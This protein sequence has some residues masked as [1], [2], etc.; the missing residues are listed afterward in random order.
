VGSEFMEGGFYENVC[1][2]SSLEKDMQHKNFIVFELTQIKKD[3]FLVS[4]V[5]SILFDTIESKILSDRSTRGMLIF[6]EYAETQSM[7]D[8]FSGDDIHSTV[9]FCYQ[10][11]RKENGAVMTII[12][13]PAQLPDNNYTKG[14]IGNTQVLYVLPT[15]ETVYDQIIEAFHIKNNSHINLMKSIK[16][17]FNGKNPHSELFIRFQDLYATAV[18]LELSPEKYYAFQTEGEEWTAIQ[19]MYAQTGSLEKSIDAYI[20]KI[21]H[22]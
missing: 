6:D 17:D 1:K 16:N 15:T 12:Q 8:T 22:E 14:M 21:H 9:A 5:M 20:K 11:L 4:V 3:P 7:V 13:S 19:Q 10:K 18:R 2:A